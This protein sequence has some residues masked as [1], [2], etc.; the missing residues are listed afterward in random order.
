MSPGKKI[1][2]LFFR[3]NQRD[4]SSSKGRKKKEENRV[5][6]FLPLEP[7]FRG[8]QERFPFREGSFKAEKREAIQSR[9]QKISASGEGELSAENAFGIAPA[10]PLM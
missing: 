6:D 10:G 4:L 9:P 8:N 1:N 5:N 2:L 7:Q 3:L